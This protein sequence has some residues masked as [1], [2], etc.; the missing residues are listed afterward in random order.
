M[1]EYAVKKFE[2]VVENEELPSF[3]ITV[4]RTHIIKYVGAGGDFQ[5]IHHDEEFAKSSGLPSV[6]AN[7]LMHGSML[8][9][10]VTDWAGYG[11]LKRY[12]IRFT[13]IVWPGDTLTFSGN[14]YK[15][16]R[17]DNENL[18]DC[19]LQVINQNGDSVIIADATVRLPS[20]ESQT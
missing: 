2:N 1:I 8:A 19:K 12:K 18:V 13:G 6:F 9:K 5:P 10:V 17:V 4:T 11:V 3:E 15:K 16:N 7:G 20:A 14:V